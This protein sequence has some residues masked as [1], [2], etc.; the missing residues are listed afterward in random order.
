M[1]SCPQCLT[2]QNR[3]RVVTQSSSLE[4]PVMPMIKVV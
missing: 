3:T 1:G 4:C 2:V